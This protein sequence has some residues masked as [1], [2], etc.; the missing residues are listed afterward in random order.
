M[1]SPA[2]IE[3]ASVTPPDTIANALQHRLAADAEVLEGQRR[4]QPP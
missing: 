1:A 2:E 4:P 3:A